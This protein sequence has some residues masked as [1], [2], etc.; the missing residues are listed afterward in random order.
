MQKSWFNCL[1]IGHFPI[2]STS[3]KQC[4]LCRW[5]H[6]SLL[7]RNSNSATTSS[8][9]N[10]ILENKELEAQQNSSAASA[11]I[12]TLSHLIDRFTLRLKNR[13]TYNEIKLT[14]DP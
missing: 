6:R 7:Q 3:K 14:A 12:K 1:K 4:N 11:K 8:N 13:Q 5:A 9:E 10:S 2:N